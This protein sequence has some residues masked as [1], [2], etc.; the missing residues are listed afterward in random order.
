M[1]VEDTKSYD[2]LSASRRIRK[3]SVIIWVVS[4]SLRTKGTEGVTPSVRLEN[5]RGQTE[6]S[7]IKSW[8]LKAGEPGMLVFK[9]WRRW[10][11]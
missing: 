4:E 5:W 7:C 10:P 11:S 6:G 2:M 1:I 8:T 3:A 9:N